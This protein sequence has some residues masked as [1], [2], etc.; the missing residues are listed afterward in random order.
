MGRELRGDRG[1]PLGVL[2]GEGRLGVYDAGEGVSHIVEALRCRQ[3]DP[4]RRL[5]TRDSPLEVRGCEAF[6]EPTASHLGQKRIYQRGIKP[7][8]PAGPGHLLDPR[9]TE[10]RVED[11]HSLG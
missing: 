11:L 10:L 1:Y 7:F 4:V 6:P 8:L 9:R 2:V 3:H 5:H